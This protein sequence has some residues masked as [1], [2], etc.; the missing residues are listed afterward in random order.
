MGRRKGGAAL[1]VGPIWLAVTERNDVKAQLLQ[2]SPLRNSPELR[3]EM[4]RFGVSTKTRTLA[5]VLALAA[6]CLSSTARAQAPLPAGWP[7]QLELG[8]SDGPGGAAA[9]M[10]TA[11]FRFRYQYLAGGVNTGSGWAT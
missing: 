1:D 11:P 6:A 5:V 10:A 9:M 8:V 4:A 2:T 3:P 7:A